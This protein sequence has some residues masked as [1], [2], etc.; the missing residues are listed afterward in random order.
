M[1]VGGWVVPQISAKHL[2]TLP[3][4]HTG[5]GWAFSSLSLAVLPQPSVLWGKPCRQSLY[6]TLAHVPG[7]A[8]CRCRSGNGPI[9]FPTLLFTGVNQ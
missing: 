6:T 7:A 3:S 2:L 9:S 1:Y 8:R 5:C 4:L